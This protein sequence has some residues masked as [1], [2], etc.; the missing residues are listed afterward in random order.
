MKSYVQPVS[1]QRIKTIGDHSLGLYAYLAHGD[2]EIPLNRLEDENRK[3]VK[4]VLA[5]LKKTGRTYL[6]PENIAICNRDYDLAQK[7]SEAVDRHDYEAALKYAIEVRDHYPDQAGTW[8]NLGYYKGLLGKH[9]EAIQDLNRAIHIDPY[10]CFAYNNR[11]YSH[12][13]LGYYENAYIDIEKSIK[14]D[15]KNAMSYRNLGIYYMETNQLEKAEE[16][17]QVCFQLDK[18]NEYLH[19]YWGLLYERLGKMEKAVV[20]MQASVEQGEKDGRDWLEAYE[21]R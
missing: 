6:T 2:V 7:H 13:K 19:Y 4:D 14:L 16:A 18:D 12:L 10:S 8:N 20:A 9:E 11:G 1:I 17:F 21:R 15:S 3:R 5:Y